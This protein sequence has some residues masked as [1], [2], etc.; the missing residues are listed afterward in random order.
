M[1]KSSEIL[2]LP[3]AATRPRLAI[4]LAASDVSVEAAQGILKAAAEEDEAGDVLAL[5]RRLG[6]SGFSRPNPANSDS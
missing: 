3:E 4:H 6:L 2:A 5:I 1:S